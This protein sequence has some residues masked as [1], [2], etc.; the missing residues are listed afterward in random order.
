MIREIRRVEDQVYQEPREFYT[1][2]K[3]ETTLSWS[4]LFRKVSRCLHTPITTINGMKIMR[5]VVKG[6]SEQAFIRKGKFKIEKYPNRFQLAGYIKGSLQQI[7]GLLH[8]IIEHILVWFKSE[9]RLW[10]QGMKEG[11]SLKIM[12]A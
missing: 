6:S 9:G 11:S 10:T 1:I 5:K 12:G 7:G 3:Q 8:T 2:S 4:Q